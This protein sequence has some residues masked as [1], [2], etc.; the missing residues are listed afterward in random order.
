MLIC[1]FLPSSF[2]YLVQM[3]LLVQMFGGCIS[4]VVA[5]GGLLDLVWSVYADGNIYIY[6]VI[7]ASWLII[8]PLSLLRTMSSLRFTSLLG[9]ACSMYLTAILFLEYWLLCDSRDYHHDDHDNNSIYVTTPSPVRH[10]NTC[11]WKSGF[12]LG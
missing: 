6:V 12:H 10:Q 3:V 7:G 8:Y 2:N 4:Y 5:F 9:F 1:L 11:F